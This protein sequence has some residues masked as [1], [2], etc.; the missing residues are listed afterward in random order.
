[1]VGLRTNRMVQETEGEDEAACE[2]LGSPHG[3]EGER[4]GFTSDLI[5][6]INWWNILCSRENA[7]ETESG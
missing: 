5:G 1:M 6:E 7:S 2:E 4:D 3:G